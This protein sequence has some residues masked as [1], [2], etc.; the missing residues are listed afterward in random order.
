LLLGLFSLSVFAHVSHLKTEQANTYN[1]LVGDFNGDKNAD[2]VRQKIGGW[3][4]SGDKTAEILLSNGKGVFSRSTLASNFDLRGDL[5]NL[6]VGDFNGDGRDDLLRQEKSS[7]STDRVNTAY[8]LLAD[9][10]GSFERI[11][12]SEDYNLNGDLTNLY[13]GD[14][15]GDGKDD[16][17]RQEKSSWSTDRVDTAYLLLSTGRSFRKIVLSEDY[18]L[19]G[20][21]TNLYVGDFNG[22]GKDDILRQEKSSWSTDRVNTAYLLLSTG[23]SFRKIVLSEDYDL[24]GDLTTLNVADFNGDGKADVLRRERG[25]WATDNIN[26]AYLLLS[27]G[28]SFERIILDENFAIKADNTNVYVGDFNADGKA[29]FIRQ[30]K[31]DISRDNVRTAEVF[32]STGRTF[33]VL[34]F[35]EDAEMKG[36]TS[37]LF[38]GDFNGDKRSDFIQNWAVEVNWLHTSQG[39]GKFM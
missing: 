9:G 21:L 19:N 6:Y 39:D 23:E 26:S 37:R 20:D 22:D 29:D 2:L 14:F 27:K 18:D 36:D 30:E 31:G 38:V 33:T 24:N 8:L 32:L 17:L 15:N 12:L 3:A 1:V 13:I 28:D 25:G 11:V 10:K 7:W 35:P 4:G 16:V 5:T 34:P